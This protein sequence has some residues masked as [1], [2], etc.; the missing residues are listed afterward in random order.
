MIID[1]DVEAL[2]GILRS[3]MNEEPLDNRYHYF[4]KN[5]GRHTKHFEPTVSH[6]LLLT[7]CFLLPCKL[8][9]KLKLHNEQ[10]GGVGLAWPHF[11]FSDY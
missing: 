3:T 9:F 11:I 8:F 1:L 6:R 5:Q 10:C 4:F 2:K 7:G